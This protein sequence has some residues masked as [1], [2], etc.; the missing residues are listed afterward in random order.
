MTGISTPGVS[1]PLVF[2]SFLP[3]EWA[4][5][6][7]RSVESWPA[8]FALWARKTQAPARSKTKEELPGW[9]P[10]TFV[11]DHRLK[12]TVEAVYALVLDYDNALDK[13]PIKNPVQPAAALALWPGVLANLYTSWNHTTA[14]PRFRLVLPTSR[15]VSAAEYERI[16]LSTWQRLLD[17][18]HAAPRGEESAVDGGCKDASRFWFWPARRTEEFLC[19]TQDGAPLDVDAILANVPETAPA[20]SSRPRKLKTSAVLDR[21]S[22]Y[23]AAIPGAIAGQHGHDQCF[24][25]ACALVVGFELD[26]A[27]ALDLLAREY[28]PRCDPPWSDRELLHK[29]RSATKTDGERGH[30]LKPSKVAN[31]EIDLDNPPPGIAIDDQHHDVSDVAPPTDQ[32]QQAPAAGPRVRRP[33]TDLGNAERFKDRHGHNVRYCAPWTKWLIWDGSRWA[34]DDGKRC[35]TLAEETAR[36]ITAEA[37]GETD[38]AIRQAVARWGKQSEASARIQGMITLATALPGIPIRPQD[39][40][41]NP[42]LLNCA[43]GTVNLETGKLQ[44]HDRR[45]LI[46]KTT[47]TAF[48]PAA[49]CPQYDKFLSEVQPD[50]GVRRFLDQLDGYS[51]TGVIREHIFVQHYG[52][53]RNGKGTKL[54]TKREILGDYAV[55][56]PAETLCVKKGGSQHPT[57]RAAF[58]GR[59]FALASETGHNA[60]LDVALVNELTGGDTI[61]CRRMREDFWTYEPTH[62]LEIQ[63]NHKITVHETS[64]G[65]WSRMAL[66]PWTADFSDPAKADTALPTKLKSEAA[67][68]LARFVRG[69]LD[70]QTHGL[71]RPQVIVEASREYQDDSDVLGAFI[72]ECT[73]VAPNHKCTAKDLY[74]AYLAWAKDHG[75]YEM[76]QN[77]LGRFLVERGFKR[78]K[79]GT[80]SWRGLQVRESKAPPP[81]GATPEELADLLADR[82]VDRMVEVLTGASTTTMADSPTATT[83]A[84]EYTDEQ[85]LQMPMDEFMK[86]R[87]KN[88]S[89]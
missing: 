64:L 30:L 70:W 87:P 8:L 61:S 10:A 63:T 2:T 19:L 65:I 1:T 60:V 40:D 51:C 46:T 62:K 81:A 3:G 78:Q 29:V 6:T 80:V 57:D 32:P 72:Q 26:E 18:G 24:A 54:E 14:W 44:D 37:K 34:I 38:A 9:S 75:E 17:A 83:T 58:F 45:D 85:L 47:G 27:A 33:L 66:V 28:N 73:E 71:V 41:K 53:G 13:R 31:P 56:I 84:I 68:I 49:N 43:N 22:K 23:L 69:C 74:A 11:R 39:L 7:R 67:G 50:A 16:W 48:D 86:L 25:A 76:S 55:K 5:G 88:G 59:R 79:S 36:S 21:A 77:K 42:W 12:A 35:T 20:A 15:P 89:H 4:H 52:V 82:Q